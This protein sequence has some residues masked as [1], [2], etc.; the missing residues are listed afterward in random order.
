MVDTMNLYD[1]ELIFTG[2]MIT[3]IIFVDNTPKESLG[4]TSCRAAASYDLR[5]ILRGQLPVSVV[6]NS[7]LKL[8]VFLLIV[9]S[10]FSLF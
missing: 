7:S 5:F 9:F 1:K 10:L 4:P 2:T 6:R 3:M 8:Q